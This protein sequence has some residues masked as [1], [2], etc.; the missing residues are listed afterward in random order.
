MR[1]AARRTRALSRLPAQA[2]TV[3]VRRGRGGRCARPG[4]D[5]ALPA[6]RSGRI[7]WIGATSRDRP[8]AAKAP[9]RRDPRPGCTRKCSR[10]REVPAPGCSAADLASV[11]VRA[12]QVQTATASAAIRAS[13]RSRRARKPRHDGRYGKEGDA[14]SRNSPITRRCRS[15]AT[16]RDS[17]TRRAVRGEGQPGRPAAWPGCLPCEGSHGRPWLSV[18]ELD[19]LLLLAL[20]RR[21]VTAWRFGGRVPGRSLWATGSGLWVIG[22]VLATAEREHGQGLGLG[23]LGRSR[24]RRGVRR[25]WRASLAVERGRPGTGPRRGTLCR[26]PRAECCRRSARSAFISRW[27][28]M[29]QDRSTPIRVSEVTA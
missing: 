5:G 26:S 19:Q 13:P 17:E 12:G 27:R 1:R 25:S 3:T 21:R 18:A 4:S 9:G 22:S 28:A 23:R 7:T 24:Q 2:V 15:G 8:S 6:L 16:E 14:A 11:A 29:V 10:G 20:H